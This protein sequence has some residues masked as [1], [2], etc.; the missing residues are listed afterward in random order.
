MDCAWRSGA[1][2]TE[3]YKFRQEMPMLRR[4]VIGLMVLCSGCASM[5]SGTSQ[6]FLLRS[7]VR[8]T[9]FYLNNEYLGTDTASVQIPKKK[10]KNSLLIAKKPGCSD[11]TTHIN[12]RFDPTTLLGILI[13]VG[14]VSI[15]VIDF[16]ITGAV[17]E[18]ER[19]HYVLNPVCR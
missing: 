13:D 6:N 8:G 11:G 1:F 14:I 7:E 3:K 15:L 9:K 16:G 4:L 10:I 2:Y 17:Q 5:F 12:T 19:T 18:A